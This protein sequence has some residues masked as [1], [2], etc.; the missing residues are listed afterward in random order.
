MPP[1]TSGHK[2]HLYKHCCVVVEHYCP[3]VFVLA[4]PRQ[5]MGTATV[6]AIVLAF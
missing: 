2:V 4:P 1:H 6:M 3:W 5:G